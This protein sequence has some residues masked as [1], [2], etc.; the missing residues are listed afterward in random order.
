MNFFDLLSAFFTMNTRDE[1]LPN[2]KVLGFGSYESSFAMLTTLVARAKGQIYK[3]ELNF[4]KAF[5]T[6][7]FTSSQ[8]TEMLRIIKVSWKEDINIH[9]HANILH[10]S[11]K[12]ASKLH[13]LNFFYQL[14]AIDKV[15][16]KK[17]KPLLEQI[18]L[19]IGVNEI[20]RENIRNKYSAYFYTEKEKQ[21]QQKKEPSTEQTKHTSSYLTAYYEI[22]EI[23]E[24]SSVAEIKKAYRLLMIKY[25]PDKLIEQS[26]EYKEMANERFMIIQNAYEKLKQFKDFN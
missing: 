5:F 8:K 11:L 13:T 15:I 12:Y 26:E 19:L 23:P 18:G 22:L 9:K 14:A 20:G 3:E 17:E 4:I 16:D 24:T 25:H 1:I 2:K 21:K 7:N 10:Q 6:D